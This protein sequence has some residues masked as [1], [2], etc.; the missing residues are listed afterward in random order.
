LILI[1]AF[2][3]GLRQKY[4][5]KEMRRAMFGG[6]KAQHTKGPEAARR[7]YGALFAVLAILVL[8][9]ASGGEAQACPPG[10]KADSARSI[11]HK[12]KQGAG[13]TAKVASV[14]SHTRLKNDAAVRACCGGAHGGSSGCQAGSCSSCAP[15][16]GTPTQASQPPDD[17]V[18]YGLSL[19]DAFPAFKS[20]P[21][22][23]PPRHAA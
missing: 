15:A 10:T 3:T 20:L 5:R 14:S 4:P 18:V 17:A 1:K 13:I 12:V 19:D 6:R 16:L 11:V 7:L 9:V 23:R 8:A 22:F 21:Q 2:V